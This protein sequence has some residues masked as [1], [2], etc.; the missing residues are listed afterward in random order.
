M[1]P[2]CGVYRPPL[3]TVI[4]VANWGSAAALAAWSLE[5]SPHAPRNG[6][7]GEGECGQKDVGHAFKTCTQPENGKPKPEGP[8][9]APLKS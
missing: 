9:S 8:P 6:P 5:A 4:A 1:P 7:R 3:V 2:A